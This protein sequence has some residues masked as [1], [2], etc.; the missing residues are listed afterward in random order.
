MA[1]GVNFGGDSDSEEI[2]LTKPKTVKGAKGPKGPSLLD[3]M[4]AA[5][6][7]KTSSVMSESILLTERDTIT[8]DLPILNVAFSGRLDGGMLTGL[9][10]L[11][12]LPTTYKTLLML[13][14]MKAYLEKYPDAIALF[15]DN[16]FG[17]TKEYLLTQGIDTSRVVHIPIE[18]IEQMKFDIVKRLDE[19]KRGDRVFIGVDSLGSLASKKEIE[20]AEGEKSTV[21]MTRSKAIRSMLRIIF[22]HLVQKDIPCV[23]VN[24]VY[25]TQ[26][27]YSKTVIPGGTAVTYFAQQ[28]FVISKS[29]EKD[30]DN[31]ITG[32]K[33]TINT[34]KSRNVWEGSKLPLEISR[35]SGIN[36]YSGILELALES[37][38]VVKPAKGKY[39]LVTDGETGDAVTEDETQTEE[40]LGVV[41]ER[42]SFKEFVAK[43]YVMTN[44]A[45]S[46]ADIEEDLA[47]V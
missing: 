34:H 19:I 3:R 30:S 11:A 40:F 31:E 9:T 6:T 4:R 7:I 12:G 1:V 35:E 23:I 47:D 37:G 29:K 27:M 15:Y 16:E 13:Y 24:H 39:Q 36:H 28:V 21:D 8:T 44:H 10:I 26:E 33:F 17:V 25:Q 46:D 43:K 14:C 41:L 42:E 22:P 18:H 32:F 38:D 45:Q 20:D 5:G 2:A